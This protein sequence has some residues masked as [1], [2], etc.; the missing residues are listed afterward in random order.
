[1]Q[2]GYRRGFSLVICT[3]IAFLAAAAQAQVNHPYNEVGIYTVENPDGCA[4][5]QIDVPAM[6]AF[7]CY[8]VLTNPYNE[9]LARPVANVGSVEFRLVMPGDMYLLY[10][11]VPPHYGFDEP[12]DFQYATDVPIIDGRG[13]LLTFTLMLATDEPRFLYLTPVRD[14][15]QSI[16]GAIMFTDL[17]DGWSMHV[18]Y[19]VSGS[20]DV[21]VFAI[22]WDGDL[23]FC[24]TVPTQEQSFGAVKALYR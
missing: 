16:P 15:P 13:T 3:V 24:E 10:A 12:P 4:T 9:N 6:T 5:A 22:N 1:M 14:R 20:F 11:N 8:L 23:S 2:P 7:D 18:M 21:P 19:P 17:D